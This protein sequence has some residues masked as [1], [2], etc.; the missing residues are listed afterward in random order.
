MK[1]YHG[2]LDVP[3]TAT[4]EQIKSQYRQLVRIYHPDRFPNPLD[5]V[6]AEE[7]LK[8]ITEAYRALSSS[9][10]QQTYATG[11]VEG[12]PRPAIAP[13]WVDFGMVNANEK[14]VRTVQVNNLGG[15][16]HQINFIYGDHN[17][18]FQ[19]GNGRPLTEN[20]PM[21]VVFDIVA[22]VR[23]LEPLQ[24]HH[25]WVEIDMDG[26]RTRLNPYRKGGQGTIILQAFYSSFPCFSH[27]SCCFNWIFNHA[28]WCRS[29]C[30]QQR[31]VCFGKCLVYQTPAS[32]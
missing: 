1:D 17:P 2:V 15:P 31:L 3:V 32:R 12:P 25:S 14:S 28:V 26:A 18:W 20:G 9:T 19:V 11:T 23:K 10:T 29:T 24:A 7:K 27:L 5:K 8:E 22:D 6:Y 4:Q 21:P 13:L 30:H 16:Y